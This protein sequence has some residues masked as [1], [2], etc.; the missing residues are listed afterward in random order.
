MKKG[1]I[2]V[3][4]ALLLTVCITL[5][6]ILLEA[7]RVH[8]LNTRLEEAGVSAMDSVFACYDRKLLEEFDIF[9]L[10]T[11]EISVEEELEWYMNQELS[12]RRWNL[13]P[14]GNLFRQQVRDVELEEIVY[15][16]ARGG[17]VFIQNI[18]DYMK[19][20]SAGLGLEV[21]GRQLGLLEK[22]DQAERDIQKELEKTQQESDK[23]FSETITEEE[24]KKYEELMKESWMEKLDKIR[25]EGWLEF[26]LP[27]DSAA[28]SASVARRALPSDYLEAA[29]WIY[30][31]GYGGISDQ[32]M[33]SE[34]LLEHCTCFT[35]AVSRSALVYELEYI[36]KGKNNDREN[37]K[38]TI[39]SLI[40]L[41]E[42]MNLLTLIRSPS[43]TMEADKMAVVMVGWTGLAPVIKVVQLAICLGW[44]FAETI[45]DVRTLLAGGNIP[46]LKDTSGWNLS[47]EQV[48]ELAG[49]NRLLVGKQQKGLKYEDYLRLLLY[50][51]SIQTKA[52]RTMDIIQL[53]MEGYKEDFDILECAYG[54]QV[55]VQT[56]ASPLFYPVKQGYLLSTRQSRM[57]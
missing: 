35:T 48:A 52:Y 38:K 33:F 40:L 11:Q 44:S 42:G 13:L 54:L 32:L 36:L 29:R 26:I 15:A 18:L 9:L 5:S 53:R 17:E 22:G 14:S 20:R 2:T 23:S 51:V 31:A 4:L 21:F 46:L 50:T 56:A 25:R 30:P 24:Q 37:L 3:F 8:G 6:L 7:A 41:R 43:L 19:Y 39:Q 27:I 12:P 16:D 1:S 10:D 57:Y 45:V 28:S 47:L 34:Y 49:G 55:R